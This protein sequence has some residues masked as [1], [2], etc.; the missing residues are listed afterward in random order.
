MKFFQLIGLV[1]SLFCFTWHLTE[2]CFLWSGDGVGYFCPIG[3]KILVEKGVKNR[4]EQFV[5]F[6]NLVLRF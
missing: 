2:W 1:C 5:E 3:L 4:F 6:A